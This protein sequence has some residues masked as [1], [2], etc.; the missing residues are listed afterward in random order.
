MDLAIQIILSQSGSWNVFQDVALTQP[1]VHEKVHADSFV[2]RHYSQVQ[3]FANGGDESGNS[4]HLEFFHLIPLR[5][6][7]CL[8]ISDKG[9]ANLA[10]L[11]KKLRLLGQ[12]F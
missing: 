10:D 12:N 4:G 8:E 9:I 6:K 5:R 7:P 2:G 1:S 3:R 11:P